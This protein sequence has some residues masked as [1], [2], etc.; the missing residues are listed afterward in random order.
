MIKIA[1]S[2]VLNKCPLCGNKLRFY[3]PYRRT[4]KSIE[5]D[6]IAVHR[7]KVCKN[8]GIVYKSDK[9]EDIIRNKCTYANDVILKA[10]RDRFV[11]GRSCSEISSYAGISERHA[12]RAG[13]SIIE[14]FRINHYGNIAKIK[15]FM[16]SYILQ[17]DGTADSEYNIIVAAK[18]AITGFVIDAQHIF[19]ESY[20]NIRNVLV[21]IRERFGT[22]SGSISD[23]RSG[24][25]EALKDAF[26][27]M[28]V[29]ICLMH[30]LRDIGKDLMEILHTELGIAISRIGIKSPLKAILREM[31]E[32]SQK[33]LY[34]IE[35]GYC[36]DINNMEIMGIRHILEGLLL[37]K[38][39]G[40]G[41]PFTLRHLNF[42]NACREAENRLLKLYANVKSKESLNYI[43][44]IMQLL[45]KITGNG[46]IKENADKLSNINAIFNKLRKA[47]NVPD[48]GNLSDDLKDDIAAHEQCNNI[49]DELK[50]YTHADI[51][52]YLMKAI[53]LVISRYRN[54]ET[55]LFANNNE[56]S[57]PRT[58]NG[59]EQF[60]RKL[61]RNIRKRCGNIAT[62]NMLAN[63]G[64][65]LAIFQNIENK[66]Y[67]KAVFG[68]NNIASVLAKHI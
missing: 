29:R 7:L 14:A 17:I 56:H 23:M 50:V 2:T 34:D 54:R 26:P 22:P 51:P 49:M 19:P 44:N 12:G 55:M 25:L 9:L 24:I 68:N 31:P 62:G 13:N 66:D 65:S 41:F 11:Y 52:G 28:P 4:A 40:Y 21:N 37:I 57:I 48:H 33:T 20:G 58:N 8:D 27:G 47:F 3:R 63:N 59:M 15:E 45:Q 6:F 5:G 32:Y 60:F 10:A 16:E 18:D 53:K 61:R 36:S 30:F 67:V 46:K 42:Y 1:F 39:S 43:N 38:S 35:N 64:V